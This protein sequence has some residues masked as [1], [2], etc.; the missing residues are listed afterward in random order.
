MLL[1]NITINS[2]PEEKLISYSFLKE[3]YNTAVTYVI[4]KN[5]IL[6]HIDIAGK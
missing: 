5:M 1:Q 4:F 3:K 2:K 6:A